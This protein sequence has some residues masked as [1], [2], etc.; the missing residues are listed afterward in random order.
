MN[1]SNIK[2]IRATATP[3]LD[4]LEGTKQF[5]VPIFQRRYIWETNDCEQLWEDVQRIGTN[6]RI[7]FHFLGSI[8]SIGDGSATFPSFRVIDGQQRLT[9]ISLLISALGR[10][11]KDRNVEIGIDKSRLEGDYLF[12]D[13]KQ[14]KSRYKQ[15]LTQHDRDTLI[16]LLEE[17]KTNDSN[18][19]LRKNYQFFRRELNRVDLQTVYKG[20]RKLFIVDICLNSNS[21]NPQLIFESLN[22]TGRML[23]QVD[24][25]R[26]Y[27]LMGLEPHL[28]DRMHETY[29]YP[30]EESFRIHYA[31]EFNLF[32]RDYLTF[33][34]Q[35]IPNKNKV[36]EHFKRF[37]EDESQQTTLEAIIKEIV[38]YAKHYLCIVLPE[39]SEETD[40]DLL[41]CV[42]DIRDLK[43]EVIN[44][45][46]LGVYEAYTRGR[47]KKGEAI[48]IFRLIESYIFRRVIYI[49][50]TRGLNKIFASMTKGIDEG[51]SLQKLKDAFSRVP[52]RYRF[53][54]DQEFR[55]AFLGRRIYDS[56]RCDY[57][58]RK[59]E[60][61]ERKEP[62]DVQ[63][64]TIERVMPETLTEQ[65]KAELGKNWEDTH[66]TYLYVIGNLTLTGYNSELSNRLFKEKQKMRG[67]F[68][69]S[70]LR[71]NESLREVGRWDETT[72]V[73]RAEMLSKQALKIWTDHDID[74]SI[75]DENW[76]LYPHLVGDMRDIFLQL[77]RRII[78]LDAS[79]ITEKRNK[80]YI[81]YS[82]NTNFVGIVPQA[83][84]LQVQLKIPIREIDDPKDLCRDVKR[85]GTY[86]AAAEVEVGLDSYDFLDYIMSLISQAFER[87][88]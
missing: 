8:V 53:P 61:H 5:T 82:L 42:K 27:V 36:Y 11:V 54:S 22:S 12:N 30:M 80:F 51:S 57:L 32:I 10:V 24:L 62:I 45:V 56:P 84:R 3:L 87:Q 35:R 4:F 41:A 21:G 75:T 2:E 34:T 83:S 86:F 38:D 65:W 50:E 47:I 85:I 76:G 14:G 67:G 7:P 49:A 58:L 72:I 69:D 29:W 39:L 59:L 31:K 44:P 71:L 15:L 60:N 81:A 55:E 63:D 19:L 43:V 52:S 1:L 25:I 33:K 66:E 70:P 68:R 16:D 48:E 46:L 77:R 28:Q 9:T 18:S 23:S 78:N 13:N 64:Y 17:G 6:D 37:V 88:R 20:I 74:R 26:N 79:S 40:Q 73:N